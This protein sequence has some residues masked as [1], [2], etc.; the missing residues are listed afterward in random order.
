MKKSALNGS[1]NM[2][3]KIETIKKKVMDLKLSILPSGSG[4]QPEP[5]ICNT[6]STLV[7]PAGI[8]R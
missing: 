3:Y 1:V 2:L 8:Y 5:Y 7:L 6:D 4:L